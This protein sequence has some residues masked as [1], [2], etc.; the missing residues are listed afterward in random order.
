MRP[1][2]TTWS[3]HPI[4]L[5]V[6]L[7][8]AGSLVRAQ[9]PCPAPPP[10]QVCPPVPGYPFMP[11]AIVPPE[12]TTQPGPSGQPGST[13]AP[14]MEGTT[15]SPAEPAESAFASLGAGAGIGESVALAAPGG[16]LDNAV[17]LTM[18]RLRY[19]FG[20]GVNRPDRA[21]YFYAAWRELSF[22][23]HAISGKGVVYDLN[24]RGPDQLPANLNYQEAYTY[25]EYALSHR[26]SAFLDVP[27]RYVNFRHLQEDP[28]REPKQNPADL[29]A[30][31]SPFYPEPNQGRAEASVNNNPTGLSDIDFG[32]KF[33][34]VADP[35]R[36]LTFQF[37][38]YAPTGDPHTGLGTGHPSLEPS[39][40]Y[41]RRLNRWE[42]QA[43]LTDWIPVG[44]GP[45]AGNVLSYGVGLGYDIYQRGN[46]RITPIVEFFGWSVL[47]GLESIFAPVSAPS[48]PH[49]ELPTT[50]GTQDASGINILDAKIGVRTYFGCGNDVYI[51]YG[52]ALTEERWYKEILRMEYRHVF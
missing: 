48:F 45:V 39:F 46:L 43:Q 8:F 18:L 36:Y 42:F 49:L 25:L 38:T 27:I 37:R 19:D 7:C 41:Y 22:H 29:P 14:E 31:G 32:F 5:T 35:C 34:L 17:P 50:H 26:F 2:L 4:A 51:G 6:A 28:D 40:L 3:L 52:H 24:A 44:G 33:A 47:S 20:F 23:P 1:R 13:A 12:Q 9:Q 21:E 16:Y 15:A 11:G 10:P 30:P